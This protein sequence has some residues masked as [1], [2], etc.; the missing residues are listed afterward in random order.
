MHNAGIVHR[1]LKPGNILL[2]RDAL[3][4]KIT[5]SWEESIVSDFRGVGFST[6]WL[7]LGSRDRF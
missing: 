6:N 2:K 5:V 4:H 1:D 3:T 7:I